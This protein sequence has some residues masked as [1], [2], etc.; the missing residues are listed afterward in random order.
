MDWANV[1]SII[2]ILGTWVTILLVYFTLREMR[3]QRLASQKPDIVI[4]ETRIAGY[5]SAARDASDLFVGRYTGKEEVKFYNVGFGVA[6]NI[7]VRWVGKYHETIAQIKEY[8][9]DNSVPIVLKLGKDNLTIS[10]QGT[11]TYFNLSLSDESFD[12]NYLHNYL[13]AVSVTSE[14][15]S[16]GVPSTFLAL[17]TILMYL[18]GHIARQ[19]PHEE[20]TR[21]LGIDFPPMQLEISFDDVEDTHYVR[22]FDV[23]VSPG[24]Y[25]VAEERPTS[26]SK[27]VWEAS[28]VFKSKG[29]K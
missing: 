6:K 24:S 10:E 19:Y 15:L 17:I 3:H 5:V 26:G 28:L 16:F 20:P 9:Y 11:D 22:R 25:W 4:I 13:M 7:R 23:T 12:H 2:G 1:V 14:G 27:V 29:K 21:D 18:K 8:C